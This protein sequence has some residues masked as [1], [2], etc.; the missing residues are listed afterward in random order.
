MK[1]YSKIY[2]AA[3]S[4]FIYGILTFTMF[5]VYVPDFKVNGVAAGNGSQI[6]VMVGNRLSVGLSGSIA[7]RNAELKWSFSNPNNVVKDY[8]FREVL[9]WKNDPDGVVKSFAKE[10]VELTDDDLKGETVTFCYV[11]RSKRDFYQDNRLEPEVLTLTVTVPNEKPIVKKIE[12]YVNSPLANPIQVKQLYG[13]KDCLP[14]YPCMNRGS[15]YLFNY[16]VWFHTNLLGKFA[17]NELGRNNA[18]SVDSKS[19]PDNEIERFW[20]K[21][22]LVQVS[23]QNYN[24]ESSRGMLSYEE[25]VYGQRGQ[26][27]NLKPLAPWVPDFEYFSKW[28][29]S[30]S[31]R[32]ENLN[33][34]RSENVTVYL[35]YKDSN[36]YGL[37]GDSIWVPLAVSK[38]NFSAKASKRSGEWTMTACTPVESTNPPYG[39][40]SMQTV[41]NHFP[42]WDNELSKK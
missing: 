1:K 29:V 7:A 25:R 2:R 30:D 6:K 34:E 38:W 36:G 33:Y 13:D 15:G 31:M 27:P 4:C 11:S 22:C 19:T 17:F 9:D 26:L 18:G 5:G 42:T 40:G 10:P 32:N 21:L 3:L 12:F 16:S 24:G 39:F 20:G 23:E 14:E 41:K 8:K 35:M 37:E 28:N